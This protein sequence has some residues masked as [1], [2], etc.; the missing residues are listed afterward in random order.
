MTEINNTPDI[1]FSLLNWLG[2]FFALNL[3]WLLL[4]VFTA[5]LGWENIILNVLGYDC[6]KGNPNAS[7]Y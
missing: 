5:W 4:A 2:W 7:Q 1:K 6:T 3:V